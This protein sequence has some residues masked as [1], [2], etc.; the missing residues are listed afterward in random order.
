MVTK[1]HIIFIISYLCI[2]CSKLCHTYN[3]CTF[4]VPLPRSSI[5]KAL[6]GAGRSNIK[7]KPLL[8]HSCISISTTIESVTL[9]EMASHKGSV[10]AELVLPAT[11]PAENN[12]SLKQVLKNDE[13]VT[14]I[15]CKGI[16]LI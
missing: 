14:S 10:L 5:R 13:I 1:V 15:F 2:L 3:L 11:L 8:K 6:T 9:L 4:N 7:S 12:Q 16:Y